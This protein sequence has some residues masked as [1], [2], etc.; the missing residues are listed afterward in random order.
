MN[1]KLAFLRVIRPRNHDGLTRRRDEK[2]QQPL[3]I[4]NLVEKLIIHC[5]RGLPV[6]LIHEGQQ[7]AQ[8]CEKFLTAQLSHFHL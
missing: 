7:L 2:L 1:L 8:L 5:K 3:L 4:V 6:L